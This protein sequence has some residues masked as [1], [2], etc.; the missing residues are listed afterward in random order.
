[1]LIIFRFALKFVEVTN[2][3]M[4]MPSKSEELDLPEPSTDWNADSIQKF[5]EEA[6][7][8]HEAGYKV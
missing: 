8:R 6:D 3:A 4:V 5:K 7:K 1:V 2:P